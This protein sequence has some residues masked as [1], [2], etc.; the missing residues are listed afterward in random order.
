MRVVED[1]WNAA[2]P[3]RGTVATIGNFDALHR[4]HQ[5]LIRGVV[6]RAR[7]VG[8]E[9]G[10]ITFEP[11][12]VQV[13]HPEAGL[14]RLTTRDQKLALLDAQ[15]ID[16]VFLVRFDRRLADVEASVFA[17]DFLG[18]R[19]AVRE[20]HVGRRFRFGRG[21]A[22]DLALLQE[23][24][25]RRGYRAIGIDEVIADGA[26]V[27]STRIREAV[28]AGE[29]ELA[30]GLLG[31]PYAVE[32]TVVAGDGRGRQLGWPT[33][34]LELS[35]EL[36]PARGVYVAEAIRPDG[37][38]HPAAVNVG[39]RPTVGGNPSQPMVEAHLLD[40]AGDLYG[41]PLE[42]AFLRRL[43]G[44][45]R[46]ADLDALKQQI[47]RDVEAVREYFALTRR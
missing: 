35:S 25:A 41:R 39:V 19:L 45:E 14:R 22:G 29:V 43:R 31:R 27:S 21:R 32:G 47:G 30:T 4:G 26:P 10:L 6:E 24:G 46:F 44:E 38:R 20:I 33:A 5:A 9:A 11:H 3:A 7:G 8:T 37:A 13:L 42:L 28:A 15:G 40:F 18:Q 12:P 23:T 2:H 36:P 17:D 34:N 16:T 1:A